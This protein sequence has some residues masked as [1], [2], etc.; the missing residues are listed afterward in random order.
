MD[1]ETYKY[2][3]LKV[4]FKVF[5]SLFVWLKLL[6]YLRTNGQ[7]G[8]LI[9]MV[10]EVLIDIVAFM[11]VLTIFIVAFSNSLFAVQEI[12]ESQYVGSIRE[13]G[14]YSFLQTLGMIEFEGFEE[15]FS[16]FLFLA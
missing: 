11:V 2:L 3:R 14:L 7:L 13:A 16:Y 8:Y 6:Y 15:P 9:R 10:T 5:A 4:V 12:V 1:E